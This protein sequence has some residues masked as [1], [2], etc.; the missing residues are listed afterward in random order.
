MNAVE[1]EL[2]LFEPTVFKEVL[3]GQRY[4]D[5]IAEIL[6]AGNKIE[7]QEIGKSNGEWVVTWRK[8]SASQAGAKASHTC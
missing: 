8:V 1:P 6:A 4:F 2:N 5:R 3:W 7:M